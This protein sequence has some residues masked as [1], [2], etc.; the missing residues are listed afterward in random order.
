MITLV[1]QA[2]EFLQARGAWDIPP[3]L[4]EDE[5]PINDARI[6]ATLRQTISKVAGRALIMRNYRDPLTLDFISRGD[7]DV[8]SQQGPATPDHVIRTKSLPLLGRDV[9]AY[10]RSYISYFNEHAPHAQEAKTMLDPAPRIVLD[11]LLGMLCLGSTAKEAAIVADIYHH[12]IEVILRATALGGYKALPPKDLFD[13]EY[14]DLEQ[15]KLRK[16]G[17]PPIFTGE[18]ALVTGAATGIGKACVDSL[19]KRGAAVI[20]LDINPSVTTLYQRPD[21]FGQR[22][23]VTDLDQIRA[24]LEMGVQRF[25]GL[26]ML[27]LNAGIFPGGC[28]IEALG[29]A[30]VQ[31]PTPPP[32]RRSTNSLVSPPLNGAPTT[33]ASTRSTPT[34][35]STL[36]SGPRRCCKP[37][38]NTTA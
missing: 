20:A 13:M 3:V 16:G 19:L 15:A 34:P 11:R 23:D 37:A 25:G 35:S 17:Q 36:P 5:Q 29:P 18:V 6:L 1:T 30:P 28:R 31:R 21:Y 33:S 7:I 10:V 4:T 32:K 9:A 26:D 14:W 27:V 24:A 38:P 8:V 12:T 2:E 22:C